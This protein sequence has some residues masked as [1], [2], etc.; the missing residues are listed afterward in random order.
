VP[1]LV[2]MSIDSEAVFDKRANELG[3]TEVELERITK[4]SWNTMGKFAFSCG[5]APGGLDDAQLKK[6]ASIVTGP[7]RGQDADRE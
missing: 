1:C 2:V 7:P 6:L 4:K 3:V 5:Y